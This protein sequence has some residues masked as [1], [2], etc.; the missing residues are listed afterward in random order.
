MRYLTAKTRITFGLAC[1]LLTVMSTAIMIGLVP[2]RRT[3]VLDG[4]ADMCETLAVSSSDYVSRGELK[5]LEFLLHSV[6]ERSDDVLSAGV[7]RVDGDLLAEVGNHR[8][9]WKAREQESSTENHVL[10]PIRSGQDK[11]GSVELCFQS[12][13]QTG[14]MAWLANAWIRLIVFVV[15][16]SYL[17]FFFY[18]EKMLQ[19]LDPSKTVPK[20][21]RAA[22]DSLAEGLLV[23]DRNQ[24]VVLANEAFGNWVGRPP[25]KLIGVHASKLGWIGDGQGGPVEKYPWVEAIRLETPQAAVML[26]LE[27]KDNP[28]RMLMT[29]A[30]PVL[31]HDGKYRGV[32]VS[33]DDVTQLEET[34]KNLSEAKQAAETANRAKSEFLA[35]MSHEI[36]TPM[37]S[38]LGYTDVM[39]RGF[40]ESA[41][42]RQEY[43]DT[44]HASGEHLLALINDILD[45]SKIESGRTELDM[46]RHSPHQ[47][48]RQV[49]SVLRVKAE[50]KGIDLDLVFEDPLPRTVRTDAVRLRQAIM[51]L[52][53]NAIKFTD[54]G[55]VRILTRLETVQSPGAD[56][57]GSETRLAI[58]V[59]DTGIGIN[60][61]SLEKIFD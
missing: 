47:I 34:R 35:R 21:V 23:I 10:V 15:G 9:F 45:L 54:Q 61:E 1:M 59:T 18:L 60:P 56:A 39:R 46:D 13:D 5:R 40:D 31:G 4:R 28:P 38:I 32:L 57:P 22:L 14:P 24:Q 55:V 33:F 29:N 2:D 44:I 12:L 53:A 11:W 43:L 52:A 27:Q 36:R 41:E 48:V 51:N 49:V 19:H 6:V 30:S 42:D 7:R 50:E 37:N 17:L 26:G 20:R 3:A 8:A 16:G 58:G 25:D